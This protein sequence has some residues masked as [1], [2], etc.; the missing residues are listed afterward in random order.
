M[1]RDIEWIEKL[2]G[3]VKRKVRI[4]FPGKGKV[5]WQF[6]SSDKQ[7]WDYDSPPTLDDWDTLEDRLEAGYNRR[8]VPY[9]TLELV[10]RLRREAGS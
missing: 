6:K 4:T 7:R 9:E 8:R 5:K 3:G 1:K 10:R 2:E